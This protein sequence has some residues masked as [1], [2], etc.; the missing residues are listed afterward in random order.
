MKTNTLRST[1]ITYFQQLGYK[2]LP[3]ASLIPMG[4]DTSLLFTN[5]GMV[6]FKGEFTSQS[7]NHDR[8]TTSQRCLRVG[9]KHNDLNQVGYTSRHHT[10]FEMLGNFVFQSKDPNIR[11]ETCSQAW[12]FLTR[13]LQIPSSHLAISIAEHDHQCLDAWHAVGI[14]QSQICR[15]PRM[16]NEW[17]AGHGDGLRGLCTEIFFAKTPRSYNV[18]DESQWLEV[19][20]LVFMDREIRQGQEFPLP[21]IS[22][23]TG[24]GLERMASVMQDKTTNYHIDIFQPVIQALGN[25]EHPVGKTCHC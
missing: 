6:P 22:V 3:S 18:M 17:A 5:A 7:P 10:F 25:H 14:P 20:N 2:S 8:I 24:M 11:K 13:E 12:Q 21:Q 23:D 15:L 4:D 1:F 19:W 16:E 9:G